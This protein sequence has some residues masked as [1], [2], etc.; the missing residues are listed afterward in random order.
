MKTLRFYPT[1]INQRYLEDVTQA[2]ERGEIVLCP[3]D[4]V[5]A[6]VCDATN[7][8]AIE[9]LCAFKG[10]NP[11]K[12]SLSILCSDLSQAS[13]Y[14]RIDN[15]AFRLLRDNTPG[16]V[17]FILPAATTLPKAFKGRKTVGVR[18]PDNAVTIAIAEA[19]GRPL[20]TTSAV[21]PDEDGVVP[22]M[23]EEVLSLY[24]KSDVAVMINAGETSGTLSAVV[25]ITDS[26]SPELIRSG[27]VELNL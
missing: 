18:I 26:S 6:L 15:K 5:Y 27:A 14:A 25:D 13:R 7:Q 22:V 8:Q 21:T 23:A 16:P 12:Q 4:S 11:A 3:T 9:R 19:L 20:L 10:L 1:S 24:E 17:T 2:L